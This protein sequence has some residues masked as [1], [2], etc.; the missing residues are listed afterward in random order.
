M[1]P[2]IDSRSLSAPPQPHP[3]SVYIHVPFCQHRCGYC[4]FT[5]VARRDDLITPFLEGLDRELSTI[6]EPIEID[7]LFFGG[8][9]PTH[10]PARR[11]ERL[12]TI[13]KQRFSL[14][15]DYEFSVE[16][17]PS[18]FDDER[19]NVLTEAGVNRVSLGVQSFHAGELEILERDHT[20]ETTTDVVRRLQTHIRNISFD[21]IFGVPGQ[22]LADWKHSLEAAIALQPTHLS[23]Y[24]L[25]IEKGTSFWS[26]REKGKLQQVG[27]HLE[28]DMYDHAMSALEAAGFSQYE[29]SS[30]ARAGFECRHNQVYWLGQ[31]YLAFGPGASR[32]VDGVRSTNHRSVTTWLKKVLAGE[33][34]VQ[35]VDELPRMDR[36]RELLAVGL[37]RS[38]GVDCR[39]FESL[40]G[41]SVDEIAGPAIRRNIEQGNLE[42][43]G[44]VIKLTRS[45]RFLADSV[46]GDLLDE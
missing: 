29:I 12:M 15:A 40:H 32:F 37:R 6:T 43:E 14:A 17:N 11:L 7:T 20:A 2:A 39:G 41:I 4:D 3:R 25:T 31:P 44:D 26:R 9:T 36:L 19:I 5:L 27:E 13:V 45:G 22:S 46:F 24:C 21:L 30:F 35:D 38:A 10:L 8:G 28:H 1:Q 23:T 34:P 33:S 18:G 42:Q 16:A